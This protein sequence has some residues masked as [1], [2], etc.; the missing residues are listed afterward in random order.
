MVAIIIR[1]LFGFI[2]GCGGIAVAAF[3]VSLVFQQQS[4]LM[5]SGL[6]LFVSLGLGLANLDYAI[7]RGKLVKEAILL[8]LFTVRRTPR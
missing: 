6:F 7:T 8:L 4:L 2:V 5:W 3:G 1:K